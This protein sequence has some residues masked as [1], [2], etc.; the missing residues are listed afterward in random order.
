MADAAELLPPGL[1]DDAAGLHDGLQAVLS[2]RTVDARDVAALLGDLWVTS[3]QLT[4]ATWRRSGRLSPNG[5]TPPPITG[6]VLSLRLDAS[7]V[8]SDG[9]HHPGNI[10]AVLGQVRRLH[11]DAAII[12]GLLTWTWGGGVHREFAAPGSYVVETMDGTF[13]TI[14]PRR[15]DPVLSPAEFR[16]AATYGDSMVGLLPETMTNQ[17]ATTYNALT[18]A[19]DQLGVIEADVEHVFGNMLAAD[20][21]HVVAESHRRQADQLGR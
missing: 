20:L 5:E 14:H 18:S 17:A 16:T 15:A 11:P 1:L 9:R 3:V 19:L 12:A 7:T 8:D 6:V 2:V 21:V 13:R 10:A 4:A